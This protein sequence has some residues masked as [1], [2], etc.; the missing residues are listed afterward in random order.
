MHI[1]LQYNNLFSIEQLSWTDGWTVSVLLWTQV[2]NAHQQ[3]SA[4]THGRGVVVRTG[5]REQ[6]NSIAYPSLIRRDKSTSE[7]YETSKS[8]RV[9]N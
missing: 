2:D 3:H 7:N 1:Y 5:Y 6:I 9:W 4:L 8:T